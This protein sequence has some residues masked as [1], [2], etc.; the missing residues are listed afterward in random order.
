MT[1]VLF[2]AILVVLIL[3]HEFGHFIV[4]KKSG[5][6]VDEFGIGFPPKM[7]GVKF[8]ETEYTIN[9]LPLGGFVRIWG[10]D[11]TDEDY[12]DT[13]ENTRSF[14]TQPRYIQAA[15]LVAGVGMN[16]LFAFA[17]YVVA[18]LIGM[19]SHIDETTPLS[20]YHSVKL[21]VTGVL[22]NVPA[23][24]TLKPNDE[25]LGLRT[26]NAA[27]TAEDGLTPETV[28]NFVSNSNGEVVTFD[29]IRRGEQVAVEV[30]P[31]QGVLEEKPEVLAAGFSMSYV[32]VKDV[33]FFEAIYEAGK[34]TTDALVGIT[35][36]L[37]DLLAG[38]FTGTSDFSQVS[39]PVGI[40][41]LVGDAAALGFIWILTFS[42][43]I[44]LNLA[45]INLFPFPALDGGR[46]VFVIIE[47]IIRRPIKP[48]IATRLNQF[49]MIALL[50]LMAVVTIHDV[51]KLF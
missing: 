14:V 7:F 43:F 8:G 46:L 3:V 23:S 39:G 38:A 25:I 49:G 19:P 13:P 42:A 47:S 26:A 9:W 50:T 32:G 45:V 37:Y 44:S 35:V 20:E 15:V 51:L 28:S 1:I 17:L 5:I 18:F 22:E 10:E 2:F 41:G 16:I 34:R 27:L 33:S 30:Q 29:L 4:A 36:G 6:R 21:F 24:E 48:I 12:K 31:E 11:P 40:I